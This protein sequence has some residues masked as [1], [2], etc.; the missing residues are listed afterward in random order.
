MMGA[1]A[2]VLTMFKP[3]DRGGGSP[4]AKVVPVLL[5]CARGTRSLEVDN[6][7]L[8]VAICCAS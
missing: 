8:D 7:Q 1:V 6:G 4:I 2:T 3:D 5:R